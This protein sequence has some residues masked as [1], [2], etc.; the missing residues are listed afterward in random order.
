MASLNAHELTAAYALDALDAREVA[1]YEE[2]LATC[3]QCRDDLAALSVPAGALAFAVESP[4]PPPELRGRILE[5]ARAERPNVVPLRSHW[6]TAV[7]V[8]AVAAAAVAVG[9]GIWAVTLH[10]S[11]DHERNARNAANSALEILSDPTARRFALTGSA[12]SNGALAV[13]PNG[14]AAIVV[15][16]LAAAP[17][18][19]TYEAWV[20]ANGKPVRAGTFPGG[21]DTAVLH[22][23]RSVPNGAQVAVT[24]EKQPGV[25]APTSK[26]VL[27]TKPV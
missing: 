5:A 21:G 19:K 23:E 8:V 6:S 25:D 2:H 16:R 13:K 7:R 1:E 4:A 24:V 26:I 27:A 15:P 12:A 9:I 10:R 3:E 20:I 22:L 17:S 11:L 18:G 14:Q